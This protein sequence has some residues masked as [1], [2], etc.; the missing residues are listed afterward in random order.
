M[1]PTSFDYYRP[2][3]LKEA[4]TLLRKKKDAKLLAGG[5]SL[6][7]KRLRFVGRALHVDF[8]LGLVIDHILYRRLQLVGRDLLELLANLFGTLDEGASTH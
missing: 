8:A 6:L 4:I 2:K 1:Y 5:H 3:N 7:R